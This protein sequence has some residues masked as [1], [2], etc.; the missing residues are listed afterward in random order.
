M[1][2]SRAVAPDGAAVASTPAIPSFQQNAQFGDIDESMRDKIEN[3]INKMQNISE[4]HVAIQILPF[5][6]PLPRI[7]FLT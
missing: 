7:V 4:W 1:T 5:V 6:K 2:S 3:N